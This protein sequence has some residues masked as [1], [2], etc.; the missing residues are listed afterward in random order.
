LAQEKLS[1]SA[2]KQTVSVIIEP[3]TIE[4]KFDEKPKGLNYLMMVTSLQTS[5]P[6]A[7][8]DER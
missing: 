8:V 7:A 1:S 2:D 6:Y 5:H 3:S 4:S